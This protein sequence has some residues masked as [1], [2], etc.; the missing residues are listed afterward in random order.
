MRPRT[1]CSTCR[2]RQ[3]RCVVPGN[4][5]NTACGFCTRNKHECSLATSASSQTSPSVA[6]TSEQQHETNTSIASLPSSSQLSSPDHHPSVSAQ[7]QILAL[8]RSSGLRMPPKEAYPEIASNYFTYIHDP[9]HNIFHRPSFMADLSDETIPRPILLCVIA[10]AARFSNHSFFSH[11]SP[12]SRG[13]VYAREAERQLELHNFSLVTLQITLLLGAFYG[14]EGDSKHESL[15]YS[16]ACRIGSLLNLPNSAFD[17]PLSREL[18]IRIWW[19]LDIVDVWS[20][21]SLQLPRLLS[22][23]TDIPYPTS[24]RAFFQMR[25]SHT[26]LQYSHPESPDESSTSVLVQKIRLNPILS[27]IAQLNRHLAENTLS[28][29]ET[30]AATEALALRLEE[31]RQQLPESLTNTLENLFAQSAS[32][33]GGVFVALHIGYYHF[34]QLLYFYYLHQSVSSYPVTESNEFAGRCRESSTAFCELLFAAQALPGA[35]VYVRGL[36]F[37]PFRS[38]P[39]KNLLVSQFHL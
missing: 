33:S 29:H 19:T 18:G 34:S 3:R 10:L 2:Q 17:S 26:Y 20:S 14:T 39:G 9:S 28:L 27:Q 13:R 7:E 32:G 12:R 30:H 35:E 21:N 11:S 36:C 38:A 23:R 37:N 31:W 25:R 1:A 24:E 8:P 16:I 22:P 15:Y 6:R 5:H 4:A